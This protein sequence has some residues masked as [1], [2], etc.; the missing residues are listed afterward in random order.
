MK[1]MLNMVSYF[2][3]GA[4]IQHIESQYLWYIIYKKKWNTVSCFV[5]LQS[6]AK[7]IYGGFLA[8]L[9]FYVWAWESCEIQYN[10]STSLYLQISMYLSI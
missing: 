10:I 2:Q 7:Q 6:E 5:N 9:P 8:K 4:E 1:K 3:V